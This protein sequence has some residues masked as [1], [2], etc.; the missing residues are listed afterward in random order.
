MLEAL[1]N[2]DIQLFLFLNG[3][4]SSYWDN[5][6]LVITNKYTWIPLYALILGYI[7]YRWKPKS[8]VYIVVGFIVLTVLTD[9]SSVH[10]FKNVFERL[11]PSHNPDLE[12][13]IHIPGSRGGKFGFIS[14]HAT[15]AFGLA[16]LSALLFKN[17]GFRFFIFFWATII[18]YSRIYVGKHYPGDIICGGLWGSLLGFIVFQFYKIP[19]LKLEQSNRKK[20][21]IE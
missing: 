7:F 6:M 18:S 19:V 3:L 8:A 10:L 5:M 16:V 4:H 14:S 20:I 15:N 1:I 21:T 2:Q 11:R 9:Q 17:K 12:G 13:L